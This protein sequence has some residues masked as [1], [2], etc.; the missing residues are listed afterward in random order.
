M[1][2][3]LNVPIIT[4]ETQPQNLAKQ[5]NKPPTL[6]K[7]FGII[8]TSGSWVPKSCVVKAAFTETI[9]EQHNNDLGDISS[10]IDAQPP[11]FHV[12]VAHTFLYATVPKRARAKSIP[13]IRKGRN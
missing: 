13:T 11:L 6:R 3:S 1:N 4:T 10:T 5:S 2:A 12:M 8:S 7:G 9:N